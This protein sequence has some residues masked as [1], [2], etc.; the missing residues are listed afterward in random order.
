MQDCGQPD[1]HVLVVDDEESL[2]QVIGIFLQREGFTPLT[3]ANGTEG[4]AL[5]REHAPGVVC[6]IVDKSMPG[7]DGVA[8]AEAIR[9]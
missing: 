2:R 6:V 3:A 9:A 7:M 5:F 8:T 4:V 1:N